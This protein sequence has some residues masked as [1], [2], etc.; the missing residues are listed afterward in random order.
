MTNEIEVKEQFYEYLTHEFGEE[1]TKMIEPPEEAK[2]GERVLYFL[3]DSEIASRKEF[4]HEANDALR[5]TLQEVAN[6]SGALLSPFIELPV[7]SGLPYPRMVD[8]IDWDE[9]AMDIPAKKWVLSDDLLPKEDFGIKWLF[10]LCF[11]HSEKQLVYIDFTHPKVKTVLSAEY[12][13]EYRISTG[14]NMQA[15]LEQFK[16]K[17]MKLIQEVDANPCAYWAKLLQL[18]DTAFSQTKTSG[19]IPHN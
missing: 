17:R 11:W 7:E 5:T 10:G 19:L 14:D 6:K 2:I 16:E 4:D 18:N 1:F 13:E 8:I 3:K 15:R 9:V 12:D